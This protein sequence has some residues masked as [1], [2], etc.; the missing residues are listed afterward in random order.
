MHKNDLIRNLREAKAS[1][2]RWMTYANALIQGLPVEKEYAPLSAVDCQFGKW[3]YG[4]GQVFD[5]LSNFKGIEQ[6]HLDLHELY[7]EIFT[8]LF[9]ESRENLNFFDKLLG[10]QRQIDNERLEKAKKLAGKLRIKSEDIIRLI[11]GLEH[12]IE[13]MSEERFA[14]VTKQ[15]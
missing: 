6:P 7:F 2:Y 3:Y 12:D 11:E 4:K 15:M 10:K 1:H 8:L 5:F 9:A 14:E 13:R